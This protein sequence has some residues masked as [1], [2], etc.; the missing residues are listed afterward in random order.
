MHL[1]ASGRRK[2]HQPVSVWSA[3]CSSRCSVSLRPVEEWSSESRT[4]NRCHCFC[5]PSGKLRSGLRPH[6]L[7]TA[8]TAPSSLGLWTATAPGS[9][10]A[11]APA[12]VC[13]LGQQSA[14]ETRSSTAWNASLCPPNPSGSQSWCSP[15]G[16]S[17]WAFQVVCIPPEFWPDWGRWEERWR[18]GAAG[19]A[20]ARS[21]GSWLQTHVWCLAET[22]LWWCGRLTAGGQHKTSVST[23]E[24][25]QSNVL[26]SHRHLMLRFNQD[27]MFVMSY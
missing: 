10:P 11:C 13:L 22:F 21:S 9:A 7:R 5:R 6:G 23:L 4:G 19:A 14:L 8:S 25:Q 1:R 27:L 16:T 2:Q 26:Y 15:M 17:L 3:W 18:S 12:G 20:A 24:A